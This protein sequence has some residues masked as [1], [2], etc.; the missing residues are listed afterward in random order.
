ML[1]YGPETIV[2]AH[3]E[4]WAVP[5]FSIY[6]LEQALAVCAAVEATGAPAIL[7]AGS[8][9]FAYAGRAAL[10]ALAVAAARSAGGPVGVHLDHAADPEEIGACLE[11]NYTSV[12][13]D[14][15]ALALEDNIAATRAI[16]GRA[17][18]YGAWVE[19]ELAG[20]SGD[21]DSS[22][23]AVAGSLTDPG[24]A[25]RF[26]EETGVAALAVAVGNVHGIPKE[27]VR[28]DLDRLAA[29]RD[30]VDVPLVLHG[31]SGLPA[32]DLAAA[33]GLG[34]AKVNINS[35]LRRAFR[36]GVLAAAASPPASDALAPL[37]TPVIDQMRVLADATLRRLGPGHANV[38]PE[39]AA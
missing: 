39:V 7:Q 37:M 27:P 23:D 31:A 20:F 22:T 33:V 14:G 24:E 13:F 34:V 29:I 1:A 3:S 36:A 9:A 25:E 11:A 38:D 26:V 10:A 6:N 12:M 15:S 5:A 19:G 35:E 21:E 8:S 18:G 28:L 17:A 16:V 2:R 30:R 32:A 4:G